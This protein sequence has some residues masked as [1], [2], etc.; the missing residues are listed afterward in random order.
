MKISKENG[1]NTKSLY[2]FVCFV[3]IQTVFIFCIFCI[4]GQ[5]QG[6]GRLQAKEKRAQWNRG[7]DCFILISATRQ[8]QVQGKGSLQAK[9]ERA[10]WHRGGDYLIL[11]PATRQEQ[12]QG[13]GSLQAREERAQ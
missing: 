6:K 8:G 10:Q 4:V 1:E 12:V 5:V 2:F 7:G 9:E 11:I 3:L 13:K